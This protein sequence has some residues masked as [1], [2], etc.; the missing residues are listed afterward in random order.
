LSGTGS[1]SSIRITISD[2]GHGMLPE[3]QA[4]AFDPFFTTRPNRQGIGLAV[5]RKTITEH[6]GHIQVHSLHGQ[7]SNFVIHLPLPTPDHASSGPDALTD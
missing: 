4:H 1:D 7:G 2:T 3:I 5:S 6:G